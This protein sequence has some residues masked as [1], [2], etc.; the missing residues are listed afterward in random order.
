MNE[1]VNIDKDNI[2]N[3]NGNKTLGNQYINIEIHLTLSL[4]SNY[5]N[6]IVDIKCSPHD[7]F[8]NLRQ[9]RS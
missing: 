7:T 4:W 8:I 6:K 5:C 2:L 9:V 3:K 1:S